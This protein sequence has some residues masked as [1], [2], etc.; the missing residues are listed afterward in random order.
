MRRIRL[1]S[2]T[3]AYC[4]LSVGVMRADMDIYPKPKKIKIS[5]VQV[6]LRNISFENEKLAHAGAGSFNV[7]ARTA[8]GKRILGRA[9]KGFGN[10]SLPLGITEVELLEDIYPTA[11]EIIEVVRK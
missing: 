11:I 2:R 8:K 3:S 5:S 10:F 4:G 1:F 6:V 7:L 9:G